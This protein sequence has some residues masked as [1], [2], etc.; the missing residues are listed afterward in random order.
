MVK[1][2]AQHSQ[3]S[4]VQVFLSDANCMGSSEFNYE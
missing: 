2:K 4:F 3:H 1:F